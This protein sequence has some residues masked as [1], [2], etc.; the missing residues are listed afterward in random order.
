MKRRS[1]LTCLIL[2]GAPLA[3]QDD[4]PELKRLPRELQILVL[5]WLDGNCGAGVPPDTERQLTAVGARVEPAFWEAYR[6]GPIRIPVEDYRKRYA[7]RQKWLRQFGNEQMGRAEAERALSVSEQQYIARETQRY[8][9][10]Y[11]SAGIS[12]L[13]LTG[14]TT[15]L[16]ELTKIAS[17]PQDPAQTAAR[18]ALERI[19]KRP[20]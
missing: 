4:R 16:A 6:L 15:S 11:Q 2:M 18:E 8:R 9:E 17:N 13:G 1:V 14:G 19:Q 7:D 3:A 12:G 20:R 10:G 5:A